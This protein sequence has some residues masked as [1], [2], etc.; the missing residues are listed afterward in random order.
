MS[1]FARDFFLEMGELILICT[2]VG[3]DLPGGQSGTS[4]VFL[5]ILF[6]G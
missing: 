3:D 4:R 5:V 6:V 2:A 1:D